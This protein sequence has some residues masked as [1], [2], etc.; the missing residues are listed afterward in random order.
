M[1]LARGV[2]GG[3]RDRTSCSPGTPRAGARLV[4]CFR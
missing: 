2:A 4:R 3:A 1:V